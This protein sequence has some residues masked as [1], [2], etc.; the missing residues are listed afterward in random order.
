MS[1]ER[2]SFSHNF[3]KRLSNCSAV[4]LPRSL[5][6]IMTRSTSRQV[7]PDNSGFHPIADKTRKRSPEHTSGRCGRAI[8]TKTRIANKSPI[9]PQNFPPKPRTRSR[10]DSQL[11]SQNPETRT[12]SPEDSRCQQLLHRRVRFH[13]RLPPNLLLHRNLLNHPAHFI[14]PV[15]FQNRILIDLLQ[16]PIPQ[17][18]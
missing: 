6:L 10:R 4:S 17:L 16:V 1:L 3:L 12:P 8:V 13:T 9:S 11:T 2:P 14:L 15:R 18:A 7:A 5:T